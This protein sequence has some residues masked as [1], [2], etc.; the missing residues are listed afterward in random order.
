MSS[1]NSVTGSLLTFARTEPWKQRLAE[2]MQGYIAF[3]AYYLKVAASDL[4]ARVES[5]DDAARMIFGVVFEDL[6]TV[7]FQQ[8]T[9]VDAYMQ[10]HGWKESANSK[11]YANFLAMSSPA[12]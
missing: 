11:R 1:Y 9:L 7:P 2:H 12:I 10:K 5:S 8:H 4:E 6:M 3:C